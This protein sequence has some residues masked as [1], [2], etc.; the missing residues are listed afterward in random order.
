[1]EGWLLL[2]CQSFFLVAQ[3][4]SCSA[5]GC[6]VQVWVVL[7]LEDQVHDATQSCPGFLV[8]DGPRK[9]GD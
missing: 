1:M 7:V 6:H 3:C 8:D 9:S 4:Y 2:Q 5:E